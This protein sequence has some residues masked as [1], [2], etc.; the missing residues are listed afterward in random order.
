MTGWASP[1]RYFA[2]TDAAERRAAQSD[3]L[4]TEIADALAVAGEY[5]ARID[6]QPAQRVVD[7]NW[8]VRQAGRRLGIRVDIDMTVVKSSTTALLRVTALRPLK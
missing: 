7:F 4:V 5:T 2:A 6:L 8:A 3:D 1:D